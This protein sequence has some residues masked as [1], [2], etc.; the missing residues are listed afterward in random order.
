MVVGREIQVQRL[1]KIKNLKMVDN[2]RHA[3]PLEN[4][5]YSEQND[6]EFSGEKRLQD[7][8]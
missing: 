4:R 3:I 6:P 7:T 1:S 5:H 8:I 2:L